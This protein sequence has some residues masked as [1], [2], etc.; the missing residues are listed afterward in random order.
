[1]RLNYTLDITPNHLLVMD[2][3]GETS[4]NLELDFTVTAWSETIADKIEIHSMTLRDSNSQAWPIVKHL[5]SMFED[6][7]FKN[8]DF[9]ARVQG[10]CD[11]NERG[12]G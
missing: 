4:V 12:M 6:L 7:L 9:W 11:Q 5:K 8:L 3:E 1:M 2:F 10:L